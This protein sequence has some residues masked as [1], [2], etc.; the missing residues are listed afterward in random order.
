MFEIA[1][2][3]GLLLWISEFGNPA[4]LLDQL[5]LSKDLHHCVEQ[6]AGIAFRDREI[7]ASRCIG[8]PGGN[9]ENGLLGI[10]CFEC[11]AKLAEP[12]HS[13]IAIQHKAIDVDALRGG[14]NLVRSERR[15]D[16]EFL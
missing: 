13:G 9:R 16:I 6:R 4:L 8:F 2:K 3:K 7:C 14:E 12:A 5:W 15:D 10:T 1:R 11:F